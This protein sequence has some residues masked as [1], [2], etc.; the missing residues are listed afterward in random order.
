MVKG[1]DHIAI[2]AEDPRALA[3]WY[4]DVLGMRVLFENGQ[5]PPTLFVGGDRGG[6]I[7]I[8]PHRG[9]PRP[10]REFYAPGISHIALTVEDFDSAYTAVQQQ[11]ATLSDRIPAAGG[12]W[13][14]NFQDPEGNDVQIIQRTKDLL[15]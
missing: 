12:G 10:S 3:E 15:G 9:Q 11:V 14:A 2:A 4:R 7:E 1:V 13:I 8:M 6:T 5:E